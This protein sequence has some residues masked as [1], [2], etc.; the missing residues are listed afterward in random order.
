MIYIETLRKLLER[1]KIEIILAQ[2]KAGD[3]DSFSFQKECERRLL[4][5][6]L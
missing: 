2:D 5:N 1:N 6:G 3:T 4:K